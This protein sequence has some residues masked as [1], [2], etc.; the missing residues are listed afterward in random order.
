MTI[1]IA[2]INAAKA[3]KQ[4]AIM[5]FLLLFCMES[6]QKKAMITERTTKATTDN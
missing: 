3:I 6:P 1:T 2:C 4:A 5:C